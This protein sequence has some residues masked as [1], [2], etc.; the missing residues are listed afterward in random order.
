MLVD[1]CVWLDVAKDRNQLPLLDLMD[2]MIR[3]DLLR[4]LVPTTV[5][6]EFQRNRDRVA[7]ESRRSLSAH[8]RLVKDAVTK[9]GGEQKKLQ[10]VMSHLCDLQSYVAGFLQR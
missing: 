4:L 7:Q 5:L 2:E 9:V 8:F 1:T 10:D 3:L 6:E